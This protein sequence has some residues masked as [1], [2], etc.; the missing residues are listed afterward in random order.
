MSDL[1]STKRPLSAITDEN[2]YSYVKS[3]LPAKKQRISSNPLAISNNNGLISPPV[4]PENLQKTSQQIPN[5]QLHAVTKNLT[6]S[7]LNSETTSTLNSILESPSSSL[8][9]IKG[10]KSPYS[11]AKDL[12]LRSSNPYSTSKF[13]LNGRETEA[14]ILK[15]YICDSLRLS[16]SNSIYISGPPGT[17]KSAQ[18]NASLNHLLHG[19]TIIDEQKKLYHIENF[20]DTVINQKVRIIKFN[21]MSLSNPNELFREIYR[22]I[23]GKRYNSDIGSSQLFK[24][25]QR[26]SECDMT[27][28]IL[29]EMDNIVTKSQQSLF[30]LF[31]WA[32]NLIATDEKPNLLLIGIANALNLTDRFLPR[33]RANCIS[34]K[35]VQ[36]LPYTAQQIQS[37]ITAKLKTLTSTT[38]SN[39]PPLVHP[40]AIMFCAKKS[41]VTTGDLRRA[42]DIMYKSL[43][44]FEQTSLKKKSLADLMNT[45]VEQLPKMMITQVVKVCSDSFNS[46]FDQKLKP[47]TLQ[48]KMLLAFLFKYE[49]K[50]ET[51]YKK[52]KANLSLN[53]FFE[54]YIE[55]C[56]NFD[57]VSAL[58]RSEFLEIISYLDIHGLVIIAMVGTSTSTKS[59]IGNTIASLNFDNYKVTSNIPK[60]EFFKNVNEISFL[61][62]IIYSNY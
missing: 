41:A 60:S 45:P 36:F 1:L 16:S 24:L 33:L 46:N 18:M 35:L 48:Q 43:D 9:P 11:I 47:L 51:E 58:K 25:F 10:N 28:L 54:Y 34:P 59:L 38:E 5:Q 56:K 19:A 57:H 2:D 39:F 50:I 26:S 20:N 15:S 61:K 52:M 4:S 12:F 27:I 49:E 42:F 37:V 29:D 31:T 13:I 32:S 7:L 22:N 6:S 55:K 62:K 21:C 30:E 3:P 44:M 8:Y 17:G 23:T 14:H 53:T 40:S